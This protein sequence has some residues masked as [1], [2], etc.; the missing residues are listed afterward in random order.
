MQNVCYI[1]FAILVIS[2]VSLHNFFYIKYYFLF[3]RHVKGF[4]KTITSL[5]IGYIPNIFSIF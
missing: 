2:L 4:Y 5:F 1:F 3:F